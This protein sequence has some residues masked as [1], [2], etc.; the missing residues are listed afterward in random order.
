MSY[1]APLEYDRPARSDRS[2]RCTASCAPH[3]STGRFPGQPAAAAAAALRPTADLATTL[4]IRRHP[5]AR[6]ASRYG[7]AQP[8]QEI[9][10]T[11]VPITGIPEAIASRKTTPKASTKR[12]MT[13]TSAWRRSPTAPPAISIP[14]SESWHPHRPSDTGLSCAGSLYPAD[15]PELGVRQLRQ[16]PHGRLDQG[17]QSFRCILPPTKRTRGG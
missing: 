14:K 10:P 13:N 12:G 3:R 5:L 6:S 4:P 2:D 17:G 11:R 7:R 9:P 8:A 16:H 15:H 1:S